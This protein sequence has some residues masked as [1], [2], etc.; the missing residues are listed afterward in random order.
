MR[1][2]S[3]SKPSPFL[4]R[5]DQYR[6]LSLVFMLSVIMIAVQVAK[7]P[8]TWYWLTGKPD[9]TAGKNQ[10]SSTVG[11]AQT[12]AS[13]PATYDV[14]MDHPAPLGE[15]EFRSFA[16]SSSRP[17]P[18]SNDVAAASPVSAEAGA[19]DVRAEKTD[20]SSVASPLEPDLLQ[21]IEDNTIQIRKREVETYYNVIRRLKSYSDTAVERGAE[22]GFTFPV[23]MSQPDLLRGRLVTVE[24]ELQR[25]TVLPEQALASDVGT[26]YE[27]WMFT[28]D[29]GINPI[30]V[31]CLDA[32]GI[33][34]AESYSKRVRVRFS[35][36][37]FKLFGYETTQ[38]ELH[39]APFF[40]ARRLQKLQIPLTV[41]SPTIAPY[42]FAILSTFALVFVLMVARFSWSDRGIR[43][44][45]KQ[46]LIE[47]RPEDIDA[48]K[49]IETF[50]VS[51]MLKQLAEDS[52]PAGKG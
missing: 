49:N 10:G 43:K 4:N 36:Y 38:Y 19:G 3:P 40:L 52:Q 50:D 28:D 22:K 32:G 45:R 33:A 17:V 44:Q 11:D 14:K 5:R 27:A 46:E 25:L 35:G 37:F 21:N 41:S 23:F 15:G 2:Q 34:P 16:G 48:L 26:L 8:K 51:A 24:G 29:S 20:A 13:A 42:I 9:Q 1:F 47:A 12:A 7:M 39:K 6:L 30:R 18:E 31:V